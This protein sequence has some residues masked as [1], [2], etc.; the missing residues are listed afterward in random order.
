[1]KSIKYATYT[2]IALHVARK[3]MARFIS[4]ESM[5][6]ARFRKVISLFPG[7]EKIPALLFSTTNPK[8]EFLVPVSSEPTVAHLGIVNDAMASCG[9]HI[10]SVI[11]GTSATCHGLVNCTKEDRRLENYLK[12]RAEI[13]TLPM[14][15]KLD[16]MMAAHSALSGFE[17]QYMMPAGEHR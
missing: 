4:T 6:A 5:A 14:E 8:E 12:N 15:T 3:T 2:A 11:P 17:S 9:Y 13:P 1:M 10:G 7:K 16:Y